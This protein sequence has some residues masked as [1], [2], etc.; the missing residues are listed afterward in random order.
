MSRRQSDADV[1]A[2]LESGKELPQVPEATR[3]RVL[4]RARTTAASPLPPETPLAAPTP[5]YVTVPAAGAL[6]A[7]GVVVAL[8]AWNGRSSNPN[9]PRAAPTPAVSAR[10]APPVAAISSATALPSA[11]PSAPQAEA[12]SLPPP[13]APP[14]SRRPGA[15]SESSGA[16]LELMRK[17]H[18]AFAA[19][20][21]ANA[22]ILIGEHARRFPGSLLAEERE[23]LRVRCLVG[24]GRTTEARR[25]TTAFEKRFPRSV[26]LQ[27][28]QAEGQAKSD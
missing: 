7:G 28:L 3:A 8:I 16:E 27:R 14:S 2:L 22:L 21:Y 11:R 5:R 12:P 1:Q 18:N 6:V 17:A 25:T 26:L 4:A 19:R 23:A 13:K 20:D 24:S 9:A 10:V 15:A